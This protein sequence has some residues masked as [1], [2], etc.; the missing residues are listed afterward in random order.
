M[1]L[2]IGKKIIT[3]YLAGTIVT[4]L[5]GAIGLYG[6]IM[7]DTA[8]TYIG[9]NR[10][11]TSAAIQELKYLP[12]LIRSCQYEIAATRGEP[13]RVR[14]LQNIKTGYQ[15]TF[16]GID[17]AWSQL[18]GMPRTSEEGQTMLAAVAAKFELWRQPC[19]ASMDAYIDRLIQTPE[20][21]ELDALYKEYRNALQNID[22]TAEEFETALEALYQRQ[23]RTLQQLITVYNGLGKRLIV[24]TLIGIIAGIVISLVLGFFT[25][26]LITKPIKQAF[27]F[28]EAMAHGDLTQEIYSNS[29]DE[30]GEMINLLNLTREGI[31]SLVL[32]IKDRAKT[33]SGVG[34][35]LSSVSVET[36]ASL[37][38]MSANTKKI[39]TRSNEQF[40]G[41]A[42]TNEAVDGITK[43]IDALNTDIEQ[44][45]AHISRSSSAIEEMTSNIASVTHTLGENERNVRRLAEDSEKGRTGLFEVSQNI[46]EVAR[47][48]EGLLEINAVMQNIASQT[49]LLSMNAAIEAA[50]AGESGKGFAVVADEIRKLAESSSEQAKTVSTVL[51]QI[52]GS[53][54]KISGATQTVLNTFENIDSGVKT[55]SAQTEQIRNAMEEQGVGN[56]EVLTVVGALNQATHGVTRSSANMRDGSH[57]IIGIGRHLMILTQDVSN[58]VTE[59]TAGIEQISA[60]TGRIRE[61]GQVNKQN[62]DGLINEIGK[63]KVE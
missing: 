58:G 19:Q 37:D 30:V 59:M 21:P 2:T 32:A 18:S 9:S 63:F 23:T 14:D 47:E 46:Q 44:Q 41:A 56:R 40:D 45:A 60:A 8:L 35:E 38:Q 55:V 50:H 25:A 43:N 24:I 5:I 36:A 11:P 39:Q 31:K 13:D 6:I 1:K 33:L 3:G 34:A 27:N 12:P 15:T 20:G 54:D 4:L 61:I 17:S 28:L 49:N 52:K 53:L 51:K 29:N 10:I 26:R 22:H 57:E 42:K 48:S 16:A 62:V 7:L